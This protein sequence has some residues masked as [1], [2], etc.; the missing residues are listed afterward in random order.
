[1]HI[2]L[3]SDSKVDTIDLDF[4]KASDK[5]NHTLL[6]CKLYKIN[7]SGPLLSWI[8][9]YI[10]NRTQTGSAQIIIYLK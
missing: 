6:I 2:M 3:E 5:I 1:M 4:S 10:S 8:S 9:S 7:I